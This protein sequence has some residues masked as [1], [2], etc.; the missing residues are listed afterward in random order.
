[1]PEGMVGPQA[2]RRAGMEDAKGW[3]PAGT[4]GWVWLWLIA[5]A[6]DDANG[7]GRLGCRTVGL[8]KRCL[9]RDRA[10]CGGGIERETEEK[11]RER[12]G[13]GGQGGTGRTGPTGEDGQKRTDGKGRTG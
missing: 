12:T 2:C 11:E 4:I 8:E 10:R 6:A 3:E 1:M 9:Q 7:S 5:A 13:R